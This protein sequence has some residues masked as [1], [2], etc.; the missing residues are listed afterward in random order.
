MSRCSGHLLSWQ[1]GVMGMLCWLSSPETGP[2]RP[3]RAQ[4]PSGPC[5]W[6][7]AAAVSFLPRPPARL[8][9]SQGLRV[10]SLVGACSLPSCSQGSL[11]TFRSMRSDGG[12]SERQ[13]EV[14]Q[15]P[16]FIPTHSF[17]SLRP[18]TWFEEDQGLHAGEL[19]R[20]HTASAGARETVSGSSESPALAS[21]SRP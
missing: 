1:T 15:I 5:F 4:D 9:I 2:A 21:T 10:G 3:P 14:T 11:H 12:E 13:K 20:V 7:E 19:R 8:T 17:L 18:K 16:T 6:R